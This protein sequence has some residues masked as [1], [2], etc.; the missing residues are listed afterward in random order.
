MYSCILYS[1]IAMSGRRD[2]ARSLYSLLFLYSKTCPFT[3]D[4]VRVDGALPGCRDNSV[5]SLASSGDALIW[6]PRDAGSYIRAASDERDERLRALDGLLQAHCMYGPLLA[7]RGTQ[8]R[9]PNRLP[10]LP[11]VH[12][13]GT[14]HIPSQIHL[15]MRA[16]AGGCARR[17]GAAGEAQGGHPLERVQRYAH[18]AAA[19]LRSCRLGC[20]HGRVYHIRCCMSLAV[21]NSQCLSVEYVGP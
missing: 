9:P 21:Y 11:K 19:M 13:L 12:A 10:T 18:V 5:L 1:C 8:N 2:D 20:L 15:A 7:A 14:C 4:Q 17:G 16:A 3:S 6:I